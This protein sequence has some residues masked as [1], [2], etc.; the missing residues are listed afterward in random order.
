MNVKGSEG[1]AFDV[2]RAAEKLLL[3]D[4]D[5]RSWPAGQPRRTGDG[6]FRRLGR[7]ARRPAHE[8]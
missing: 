8:D 3:S 2:R 4:P 1:A 5:T 6:I 7:V